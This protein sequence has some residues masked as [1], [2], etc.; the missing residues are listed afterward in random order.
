MHNKA[1]YYITYCIA[2]SCILYINA[3]I[4]IVFDIGTGGIFI[5]R[6]KNDFFRL[7]HF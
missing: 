5:I 7:A 4:V 2:L 1:I 6:R 3:I